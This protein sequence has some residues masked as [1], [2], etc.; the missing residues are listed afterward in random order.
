MT[1]P[2]ELLGR[3]YALRA[4]A[5]ALVIGAA[6]PFFL[7][8]NS[9]GLRSLGLLGILISVGLVRRSNSVVQRARGQAGTVWAPAKAD[10]RVGPLVWALT[11]GSLV[12]CVAFYF[13]M[14]VDQAH[15]GKEVWPVYAFAGAAI[16]L[17]V[18]SGYI[19][20]KLFQ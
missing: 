4:L 18:T 3:F 15:G 9:F 16:A 17:A 7:W 11:G 13:A 10:R 20:M 14:Y 12:A 6:V 19:A 8:P 5:L 2:T 1:I